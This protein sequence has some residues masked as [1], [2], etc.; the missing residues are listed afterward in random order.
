MKASHSPAVTSRSAM[1]NGRRM[2]AVPGRLVVVREPGS[3]MADLDDAVAGVD[4]DPAERRRHHRHAVGPERPVGGI[5]RVARQHVLD[6]HEEQLLVLLLVVHAEL[7]QGGDGGERVGVRIGDQAGE[8]VVDGS[9]VVGD[10][11]AG[12]SG[13]EPAVRPRVPRPDLLVVRVEQEVVRRVDRL[14]AGPWGP[15]T[16][17]SKNQVVWAR[18]HL[19]GLTS[20][21][22]W[23]TWSSGASGS[24]SCSVSCRVRRSRSARRRRSTAVAVVVVMA[25]PPGDAAVAAGEAAGHERLDGHGSLRSGRGRGGPTPSRWIDPGRGRGQPRWPGPTPRVRVSASGCTTPVPA[26]STE[27]QEVPS[28][29]FAVRLAQG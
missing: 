2:R 29:A 22:D 26:G 25:P 8:R 18:C 20:S 13:D 12:G 24:A 1:R 28:S 14:V 23:T 7:D 19:V 3:G 4:V 5:R 10:L 27:R 11:V 16:N 21:I 17:V 15:R 6:V 9:P